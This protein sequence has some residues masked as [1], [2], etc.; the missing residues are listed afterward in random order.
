MVAFGDSQSVP[1]GEGSEEGGVRKG[2]R[3][4]QL[5]DG[6]GYYR[7]SFGR[8]YGEDFGGEPRRADAAEI[9][10]QLVLG[11]ADIGR[12]LTEIRLIL[13]NIDDLKIGLEDLRDILV[14]RC[15]NNRGWGGA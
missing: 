14:S 10:G 6:S 15:G 9:S 1:S 3:R 7:L 5:G 13:A 2:P 8:A 12:Q 11:L 4:I